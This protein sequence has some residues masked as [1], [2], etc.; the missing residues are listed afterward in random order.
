MN[1]CPLLMENDNFYDVWTL[2]RVN[3][4]RTL[5][6]LFTMSSTKMFDNSLCHHTLYAIMSYCPLLMKNDYFYDVWSLNQV[7]FIRSLTDL[8]TMLS[9]KISFPSSNT[10]YIAIF[11]QE[12]LPFVCEMLPFLAM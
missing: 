3:L 4:I 10:V 2:N 9:T 5:P 7:F 12:L 8:F 11:L 6:N 1:Y